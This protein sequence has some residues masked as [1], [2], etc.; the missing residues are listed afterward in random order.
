[1]IFLGDVAIANGDRFVFNNFPS[2]FQE[3]ENCINLEG[4]ISYENLNN[5]KIIYNSSMFLESFKNFKISSAFLGNNHILDI[6]RGIEETISFLDNYCIDTFGY[7]EHLNSEPKLIESDDFLLL[8]YGWDVIGCKGPSG[9]NLGV[10][11]FNPLRIIDNVKN[12]IIKFPNKKI[13]LNFHWNYEFEKYPQPMFRKLSFRLIDLGVH[14]IVGHHPHIVSPIEVYKGKIIAYSIGNWAFSSG[15]FINGDLV[16]PEVSN[17]QIALEIN[18]E[19]SIIHHVIFRPPSNVDYLYS[20]EINI[21]SYGLMPI[22]QGFNDHE[23][24]I[25]FKNHRRKK[26]FLPI[27]KDFSNIIINHIYDTFVRIRTVIIDQL[28]RL[29]IKSQKR[30]Y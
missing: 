8:G 19:K 11:I 22:F 27:Y 20:E 21:N 5:T 1:M 25:W 3:Q 9:R 13:I 23:Y 30:T 17:N 12:L 2:V 18:S 15:K 10:Q 6:P 4:S 29:K 28:V 16:F 7:K 14:A 24:E 26:F